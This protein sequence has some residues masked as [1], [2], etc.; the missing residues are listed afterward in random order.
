MEV[1]VIEQLSKNYGETRV[2]DALSLT[3][4]SEKYMVWWER[5]VRAR[6]RYLIV[7]WG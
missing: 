4:E 2:L 3:Y 5:T 6:L 1:I 7:S